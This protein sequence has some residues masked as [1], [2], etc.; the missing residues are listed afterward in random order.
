M[1]ATFFPAFLNALAPGQ[2]TPCY[3][4]GDI[5]LAK[6][7]TYGRAR[8]TRARKLCSECPIQQA[9]TDWAVE[10]GETD[11][12]WGGLTPRERAAIRRRPV[13]AQ[14]ECGTETAWRA[15]LSRGESCHI[16]HV[17]QEARI[18]DDRLARLDA[19][20]RTG[21]SLAG[22]RLELLL[23]LSTCPACRAARNA[24]Y[25]GRPRP[26]KWYRRGGARTA[27]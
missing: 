16:C 1:E 11:G 7:G 19:E 21:G 24:Y 4:Q 9:C 27:A 26:A 14:P 20:H 15:H 5:Y 22:Y 2:R 10:T 25:R 8:A 6:D 17:E 3:G 13:V 18:R 12:I 23:G